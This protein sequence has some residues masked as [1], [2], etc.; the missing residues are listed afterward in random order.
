[1]SESMLSI[2]A[3]HILILDWDNARPYLGLPRH[4]VYI[5]FL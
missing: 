4:L 5:T 2:A 3:F 1:M